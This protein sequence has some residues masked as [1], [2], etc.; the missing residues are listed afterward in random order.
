LKGLPIETNEDIN[1]MDAHSLI[2][3]KEKEANIKRLTPMTINDLLAAKPGI[4]YS[5][6]VTFSGAI[7]RVFGGGIPLG[8]LVIMIFF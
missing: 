2:E 6:L 3:Y 8:Q 7:D 4:K 1:N 5:K